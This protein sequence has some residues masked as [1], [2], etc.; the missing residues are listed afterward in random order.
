[1][2]TLYN[3]GIQLYG[4]SIRIA[5][6]FSGKARD[7]IGGRKNWKKNLAASNKSSLPTIWLHAASLGEMEQGVPI[8]KQLRKALPQHQFLI[9]F[10]SPS[11]FNNF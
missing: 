7:F 2:Q 3:F 8:L 11:G 9:T 1:M 5:S 10:F 4:L 6:L